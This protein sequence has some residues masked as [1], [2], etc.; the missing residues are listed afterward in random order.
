MPP[1]SGLV[2]TQCNGQV[3]RRLHTLPPCSLTRGSDSGQDKLQRIRIGRFDE[4]IV[5][6]RIGRSP[7]I[8]VRSPT[9]QRGDAN[10]VP[11]VLIGKL[12]GGGCGL[13]VDRAGKDGAEA[14]VLPP[15]RIIEPTLPCLEAATRL[16][17]ARLE[18]GKD[19][20]SFSVV[21][22]V[23]FSAGRQPGG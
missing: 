11:H 19:D 9:G 12:P 2:S 4:V 7:A 15:R 10:A 14:L 3:V 20:A 8:F 16:A 5:K 18:R 17:G 21:W 22:P 13:R 23:E 1:A 6:A